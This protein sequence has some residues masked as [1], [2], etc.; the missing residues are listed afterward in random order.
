M[1]WPTQLN[2]VLA[3]LQVDLQ[4]VEAATYQHSTESI[5]TTTGDVIREEEL[6]LYT[7]VVG[8]RVLGNGDPRKY[9]CFMKM[10]QLY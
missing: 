3:R 10:Q 1:L 2:V 8:N 4:Q 7:R 6:G 9:I 5:P